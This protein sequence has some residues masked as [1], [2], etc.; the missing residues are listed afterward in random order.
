M[1]L[2]PRKPAS[3]IRRF[4]LILL[5]V[6]GT[7][8]TALFIPGLVVF[9][10]AQVLLLWS[11]GLLRR[12]EELA[13]EGPYAIVRNPVYCA[14][15]S[16][17]IAFFLLA[18][19]GVALP[20]DRKIALLLHVGNIWLNWPVLVAFLLFLPFGVAHYL[21]RIKKEEKELSC[22]FG[23]EWEDFC[24]ATPWR[25]VPLPWRFFSRRALLFT[26]SGEV[27][28]RNRVFTRV[29]KYAF[30][31]YVFTAKWF[32][33]RL[34]GGGGFWVFWFLLAGAVLVALYF[35]FARVEARFER[36]SN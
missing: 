3:R 12:K 34:D 7:P 33:L 36:F 14:M 22:L 13:T 10:L 18:G 5:L 29:T 9:L 35:L 8:L 16:G 23:G 32:W 19:G 2:L 17:N 6:A 11:Y 25:L 24:R 30:W 28:L 20:D 26:W 27:A 1:R 15:L 31:C 4:Y 21:R